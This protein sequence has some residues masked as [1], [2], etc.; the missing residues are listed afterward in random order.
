VFECVFLHKWLGLFVY[1]F[2]QIMI[3]IIKRFEACASGELEVVKWL[4]SKGASE[5]ARISDKYGNTPFMM[6]LCESG[7]ILVAS[8]LLRKL[9]EE[10]SDEVDYAREP[11]NFGSTPLI[12]ACQRGHFDV[13]RWLL[14]CTNAIAD[15]KQPN[16]SGWY[17]CLP[18]SLSPVLDHLPLVCYPL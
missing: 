2:E 1:I 12:V 11:N 14:F 3:I 7:S 17:V 4:W 13:V 9:K 6:A 5:D 15:F 8:W 10:S 16:N 18:A